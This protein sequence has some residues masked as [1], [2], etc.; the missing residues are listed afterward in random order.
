MTHGFLRHAGATQDPVAPKQRHIV[1]ARAAQYWLPPKQAEH[2]CSQGQF[3]PTEAS[4]G[5]EFLRKDLSV[6][7]AVPM[8]FAEIAQIDGYGDGEA[9]GRL[10]AQETAL[11]NELHRFQNVDCVARHLQLD[12]T[13][14]EKR[15]H[16]GIAL[17]SKIGS[18]SPVISTSTLSTPNA[19]RLASKCSTIRNRLPSGK[20]SAG[21]SVTC[22][23]RAVWRPRPVNVTGVAMVACWHGFESWTREAPGIQKERMGNS[24]GFAAHQG[25][26]RSDVH[27]PSRTPDKQGGRN[28]A[29][30]EIAAQS[31]VRK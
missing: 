19:E 27:Q 4:R 11:G 8:E 1:Q 6:W 30:N 10:D 16:H 29:L 22:A 18:S 7:R 31:H 14:G 24:M 26:R 28:Y 15:L 20:R 9:A 5:R 17:P 13:R 12:E 2:H 23:I 25:G 3:Q 21:Q